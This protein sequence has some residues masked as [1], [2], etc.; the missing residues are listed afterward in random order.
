MRTFLILLVVVFV[1]ATA[2]VAYLQRQQMERIPAV[3]PAIGQ[4]AIGGSFTL[5]DQHGKTVSSRDFSSR[6]RL[7]FFGFTHC[8]DIC[9]TALGT[10]TAA[11]E[12]LGEKKEKLVPIF[13]TV[14][15]ERDTPEVMKEYA[16]HFDKEL[17]ALTGKE[18]AI[19]KVEDDYK[20]YAT[21]NQGAKGEPYTVSH[22]GYMYLMD[23]DG[24]YLT[25]FPADISAK[26]L[27]AALKG[28]VK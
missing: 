7:I 13:I 17:V 9:P 1:V 3:T 15:P 28:F 23:K 24:I 5:T 19:K 14:D 2:G 22:S 10:I 4:A 20:V 27:A 8:P 21:R 12:E 16:S 6:Y 26:K 18:N 25:H 11:R